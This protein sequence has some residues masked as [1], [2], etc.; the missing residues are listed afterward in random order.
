MPNARTIDLDAELGLD[1]EP[2]PMH[3]KPIKILGIEVRVVCDLNSF[4]LTN[5]TSGDSGAIM[6]FLE[7]MIH[8]EDWGAFVDAATK[9]PS[10]RGEAGNEVLIKIINRLTE[11]A[12]ERP[13]QRPSALPRGASTRLSKP[14]SAASTASARGKASTRSR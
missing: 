4:G 8:P 14:K 9:H 3:L 10:L 1:G 6:K 13:T 12:A 2:E 5:L 11:V 7:S